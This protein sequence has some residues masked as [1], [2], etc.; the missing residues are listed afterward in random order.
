MSG[1]ACWQVG[2]QVDGLGWWVGS[3]KYVH[4]GW[5]CM[6]V[7]GLVGLMCDQNIKLDTLFKHVILPIHTYALQPNMSQPA[8]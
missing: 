3:S 8:S 4:S 6:Y 1:W 7:G 5:V 2:V